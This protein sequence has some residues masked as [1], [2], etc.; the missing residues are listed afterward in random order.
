MLISANARGKGSDASLTLSDSDG[1][2]IIWSKSWSAEDASTVNLAQEI[3]RSA[4]QAALCLT[5]AKG[6]KKR[7][8]QPALSIFMSGCVGIGDSEWSDAQLL[9]AFERVVRLAP[10]FPRG[11]E[12]LAIG[13]SVAAQ[14]GSP[15][16][17]KG[18][19]EA[20]S[21]ARK[22]NPRSGLAYLAETIL[23]PEDRAQVL[24]RLDKGTELEP[25]NALLQ[26]TRADALQTVGRLADSVKGAKRAVELDPLA[27]FVRS[28][29]IMALTY[30]GQFSA[31]K[32]D[33]AEARKKWPND[34]EIDLAEF[35]LQF[36]YGDPLAAEKLMPRV[37]HYSDA[38]LVPY[39]KVVAAR[40]DPTPAKIDDAIN[41]FRSAPSG[42][43]RARNRLLLALGLFGKVDDTY[44][45]LEESGFQRLVD[46]S[47]LFRPEFAPVR[48]DPRFMKVAAD[49]KLL[50]YWRSTGN[51][52]DFCTSEQLAYDCKTEA[53]K[54][55]G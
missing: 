17:I 40:I 35:S 50:S 47:I 3:S 5:E 42:D 37:L 28:N 36:R 54:Y 25:D 33:I 14:S 31:A 16:A 22:L 18:A 8:V 1:H 24:A 43:P 26:T 29:Y 52:P 34:P 39:R 27:S 9:A 44:A 15:A 23:N 7:L 41:I 13:R 12:Y 32:A 6:G 19:R 30:A 46:P 53:A 4:S 11:W 55:P 45:L 10:E 51:W 38:Q 48:A 21:T 20:I 49:L 2:T